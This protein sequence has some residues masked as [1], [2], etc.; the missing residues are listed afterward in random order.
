[1]SPQ[2]PCM[3]FHPIHNVLYIHPQRAAGDVFT[4]FVMR[5]TT[6]FNK[7]IDGS[8]LRI[9]YFLCQAEKSVSHWYLSTCPLGSW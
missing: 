1:M 8:A 7:S 2:A 6:F 9:E 4:I 3:T 5:T